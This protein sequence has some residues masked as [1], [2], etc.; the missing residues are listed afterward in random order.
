MW[1]EVETRRFKYIFNQIQ[2]DNPICFFSIS[3]PSHLTLS[4]NQ[5]THPQ[6]FPS[7]PTY[8]TLSIYYLIYMHVS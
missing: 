4:S 7:H 1:W 5:Q 8:T 2:N 6:L 3:F